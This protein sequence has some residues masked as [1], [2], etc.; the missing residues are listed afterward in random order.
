MISIVIPLHNRAGLLKRTLESIANSTFRPVNLILVNNCCTDASMDIVQD[1][2]NERHDDNL[3]ITIIEENRK[4]A[5]FARNKGLSIVQSEYVYFFDNDDIFDKDF[6]STFE[7]MIA[8]KACKN[9]HPDMIC[10]LTNQTIASTRTTKVRNYHFESADNVCN[11]IIACP[12]STPSMIFRTEFLRK[13]GGWN[14]EIKVWQ[15]WELGVRALLHHPDLVWYKHRS[16]HNIIVHDD[17]IT[18]NTSKE[19]RLNTIE[20][21]RRQL[22]DPRYLRALKIKK[23]DLMFHIP[24]LWM[25]AFLFKKKIY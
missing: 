3:H 19:D 21:V 24:K 7:K 8:A 4:G 22:R 18:G 14:E 1:F 6:L 17:S 20:I 16:F 13:I 9:Q 11:Q 25:I 2:I 23:F 12:L 15:D 10:L 5:N